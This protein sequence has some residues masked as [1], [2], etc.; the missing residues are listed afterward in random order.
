M[1]RIN[2]VKLS[3]SAGQE[4]LPAAAAKALR[5]REE[6][7]KELRMKMGFVFQ[8]FNLFR[9]MTAIQNVME[10][11]ITARKIPEAQA[12]ETAME[13]LQKIVLPNRDFVCGEVLVED[14]M[15]AQCIATANI[16]A[17]K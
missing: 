3:V 6:E 8:S 2:N 4:K 10:G 14:L 12:R 15:G 9:N 13:M 17:V 7:I 5:I 11:L 16:P 1:I